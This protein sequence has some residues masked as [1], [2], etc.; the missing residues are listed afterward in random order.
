MLSQADRWLSPPDPVDLPDGEVHVWRI[1]LD[2]PAAIAR[3]EPL[4]TDEERQRANRFRAERHR[5]RFIVGRGALRCLLG[6]YLAIAP[7]QVGFRYEDFGKPVLEPASDMD[8]NLT[9]SH[10]LAL[11]AVAR[12]RRLGIDLERLRD[13]VDGPRIVARFFSAR[14]QADYA[15]L[16]EYLKREGFFRGWT[17]KEAYLKAIGVGITTPLDSFSVALDPREPAALRE[18]VKDPD[19]VTRWCLANVDPDPDHVGALA[20]E[21][22]D[23]QLRYLDFRSDFL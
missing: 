12:R 13:V 8:F 15:Q 6:R 4:L 20:V 22:S 14:E 17:R 23:W 21:G 3:L 18:V 16:P 7:G 9:H 2:Q 10:G 5:E 1:V 11:C 19:E